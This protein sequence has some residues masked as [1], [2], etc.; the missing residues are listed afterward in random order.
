MWKYNHKKKK[1]RK[2]NSL[3][4]FTDICKA[5]KKCYLANNINGNYLNQSFPNEAQFK[6]IINNTA[7]IRTIPTKFLK[8]KVFLN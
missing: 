8:L 5:M 1:K 7:Q 2:T 4:E 6:Q 3:S